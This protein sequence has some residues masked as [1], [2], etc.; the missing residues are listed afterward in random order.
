MIKPVE[1][2][3]ENLI[4]ALENRAASGLSRSDAIS[5]VVNNDLPVI[6]SE[7]LLWTEDWAEFSEKEKKGVANKIVRAFL[8]G[9]NI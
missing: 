4:V 6:L 2:L 3:I 9:V 7:F 1:K 5:E 8:K